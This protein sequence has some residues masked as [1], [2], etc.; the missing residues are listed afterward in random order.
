MFSIN[1]V[2]ILSSLKNGQ[3]LSLFI[4]SLNEIVSSKGH[5]FPFYQLVIITGKDGV[6][7]ITI[8]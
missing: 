1:L 5:T 2:K 4:K 3:S 6:Y 8:S 7:G